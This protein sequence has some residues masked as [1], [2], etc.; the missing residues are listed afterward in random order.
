[1]L[2][3]QTD[4]PFLNVQFILCLFLFYYQADLSWK[5]KAR[6]NTILKTPFEVQNPPYR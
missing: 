3:I 6:N 2:P 1:M 4:E 5:W